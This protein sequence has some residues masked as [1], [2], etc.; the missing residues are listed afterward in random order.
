MN[1]MKVIL[2][3]DDEETTRKGLTKTL[4]IWSN[5]KHE[6]IAASTAKEA[7]AIVEK[8]KIHILVTDICMPDLTGLELVKKIHSLNQRPVTLIISGHSEFHFAQEAISLG[9][10]NYLVKPVSKTKLIEAVEAAFEKEASQERAGILEKSADPTLV[11][12]SRE[13]EGVKHPVK[14]AYQFIEEHIHRQI[15]LKEVADL[16]HLNSSYFS[17][18]FKEQTGLT[19][20]EYITRTRLQHAKQLLM[21]TSMPIAEIAEQ[22]GYQTAKYFNRL[23]KEYE[24][25][26]P[27]AYRK[28]KK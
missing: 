13:Q 27:G 26:T 6:V 2:I 7:L 14:T 3:V 11:H 12:L 22:S 25:M 8:K 23:F 9:V 1:H 4:E 28:S 21:T 20:S 24:G 10:L 16:V 18:L 15:S 17:V 5:G 19:F